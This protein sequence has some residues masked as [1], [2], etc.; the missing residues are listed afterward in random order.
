MAGSLFYSTQLGITSSTAQF[1][2]QTSGGGDGFAFVMQNDPRGASAI[3]GAGG[4][5]GYG[6][7]EGSS[8]PH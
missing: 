7:I 8:N 1:T 4:D 6:Y 3:G 5:L 2:Y